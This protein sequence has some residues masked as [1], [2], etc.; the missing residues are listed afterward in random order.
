MR[1]PEFAKVF[2][3]YGFFLAVNRIYTDLLLSNF[4]EINDEENGYYGNAIKELV[5]KWLT[6]ENNNKTVDDYLNDI[7]QN[8]LENEIGWKKCILENPS[9]LDYSSWKRSIFTCTYYIG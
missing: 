5:D 3:T 9:I 7:I 6:S 8:K 4:W 1:T 2:H